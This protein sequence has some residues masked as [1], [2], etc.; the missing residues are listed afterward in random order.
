[1]TIQPLSLRSALPV[2]LIR[3][4]GVRRLQR[5]T[6]LGE[7]KSFTRQASR[8]LELSLKVKGSTNF[9][10]TRDLRQPKLCTSSAGGESAEGLGAL[11][12]R[13]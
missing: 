6:V 5:T 2:T 12:G 11:D 1:M 10:Q 13:D 7:S 4:G 9:V 8:R 3:S